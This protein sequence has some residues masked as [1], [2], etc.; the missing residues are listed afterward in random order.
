MFRKHLT[1][2]K[3]QD[4]SKA[5]PISRL[6]LLLTSRSSKPEYT[7]EENTTASHE[8]NQAIKLCSQ[9]TDIQELILKTPLLSSS[10]L[11]FALYRL[12]CLAAFDS[13]KR[14]AG[15][16]LWNNKH[17]SHAKRLSFDV[18]FDTS[19]LSC[20]CSV[21]NFTIYKC[22]GNCLA[23]PVM[24][25]FTALVSFSPCGFPTPDEVDPEQP[26]NAV[27][28][29]RFEAEQ[30]GASFIWLG[31]AN[32]WDHGASVPCLTTGWLC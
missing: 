29:C 9:W 12:G 32:Y 8:T 19:T 17:G 6:E 16:P 27:W 15:E 21:V 23:H 13:R 5:P 2:K 20:K 24:Y 26:L 4:V 10:N 18:D 3:A 11:A 22:L 1:T 7:P 31:N 30:T 25:P 14:I 28:K